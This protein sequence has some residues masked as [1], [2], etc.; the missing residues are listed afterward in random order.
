[1]EIKILVKQNTVQKHI[2]RTLKYIDILPVFML[3]SWSSFLDVL[4]EAW[5]QEKKL[6]KLLHV[7][8]L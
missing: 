1:M 6:S 4:P 7:I 5:A 3:T 2:P 8:P